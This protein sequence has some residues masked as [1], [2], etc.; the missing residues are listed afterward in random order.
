ML[1]IVTILVHVAEGSLDLDQQQTRDSLKLGDA[2][3]SIL[4]PD[5]DVELHM[6]LQRNLRDVLSAVGKLNDVPV[7]QFAQYIVDLFRAVQPPPPAGAGNHNNS[8]NDRAGAASKLDQYVH[9]LSSP[10]HSL[11]GAG[12]SRPTIAQML[13]RRRVHHNVMQIL[14]EHAPAAKASAAAQQQQNDDDD[15]DAGLVLPGPDPTLGVTVTPEDDEVFL[16]APH[17]QVSRRVPVL[18]V[19]VVA[20]RIGGDALHCWQ[21]IRS[22]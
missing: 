21:E 17:T 11:G 1:N 18:S 22:S 10:S 20:T 6:H 7:P 5:A 14:A 16:G 19:G 15:G 2:I 4:L 13:K 9:L 12:G 8:N 3:V